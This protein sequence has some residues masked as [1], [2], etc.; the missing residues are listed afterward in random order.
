MS[1][2]NIEINLHREQP[3]NRQYL[4]YLLSQFFI[5]SF[6]YIMVV[7]VLFLTLIF[8]I[9]NKYTFNGF[10]LSLNHYADVVGVH[11]TYLLPKYKILIEPELFKS[12]FNLF[13]TYVFILFG[14]ISYLI[15]SKK[16]SFII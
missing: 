10:F 4:T 1:K 2:N 15:V 12:A 8:F 5:A 9:F 6:F 7:F 13:I 11:K 14:Y 3:N 16:L